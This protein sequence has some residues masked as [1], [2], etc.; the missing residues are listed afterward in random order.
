MPT[1]EF[2]LLMMSLV[3]FVPTAFALVLMILPRSAS[4]LW[5]VLGGWDESVRWISLVGTA[6]TLILSMC[7]FIDYY[8]RLD[9]HSNNPA[10]SLLS[11]RVAEAERR[12]AAGQPIEGHD[13]VARIP[14]IERFNI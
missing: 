7:M 6:V 10:N 3:I 8:Q 14:W 11:A 2:D 1:V 4:G 12:E 5:S 9:F 13:W